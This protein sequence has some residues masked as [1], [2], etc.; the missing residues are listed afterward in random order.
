MHFNIKIRYYLNSLWRKTRTI[1]LKVQA[2][3]FWLHE[4]VSKQ[5]R[6]SFCTQ[7]N[8]NFHLSLVLVE[9]WQLLAYH[10]DGLLS[11]NAIRIQ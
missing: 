11:L 2:A 9:H 10:C 8:N 3:G 6:I 4:I 7:T 1:V 5:Q